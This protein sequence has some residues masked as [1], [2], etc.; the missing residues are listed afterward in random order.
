MM[1]GRRGVGVGVRERRCD[2][3]MVCGCI[4][5]RIMSCGEICNIR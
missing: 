5:G 4:W 1:M 2:G 3:V